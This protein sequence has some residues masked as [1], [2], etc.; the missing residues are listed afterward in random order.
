MK[1]DCDHPNELLHQQHNRVW[2]S[3]S[4]VSNSNPIYLD[5]I[6]V[7]KVVDNSGNF[8]ANWKDQDPTTTTNLLNP[9]SNGDGIP[10]GVEDIDAD[11][12]IDSGVGVTAER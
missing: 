7:D 11:G 1:S 9:G 3:T 8:E 2:I 5:N 4:W 10:D 12:K 6:Y